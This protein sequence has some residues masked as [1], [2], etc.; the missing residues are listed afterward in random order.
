MMRRLLALVV[1]CACGGS[2]PP[3]PPVEPAP[4]PM[5]ATVRWTAF[6]VPHVIA[7]D[8]VGLGFGQGWATAKQHLCR[9]ADQFVRVR[10]E[11][12]R[13]F[14]AGEG[15]AN[16]DSDFFFRHIEIDE[17]A[18]ALVGGQSDDAKEISR[19]WVAGYNHFL[20][21]NPEAPCAGEPWVG[22]IETIDLA[23]LAVSIGIIASTG[24]FESQIAGAA[25]A[26]GSALAPVDASDIALASNAWALGAERTESG[27]G[28][29]IA[30]P[31]FPWEG[32]LTFSEIHLT[33]RSDFDVYGAGIPGL[34][35]VGIGFTR[36]HAWTHTVSAST[37]FLL[38]RLQLVP[39]EPLQYARDDGKPGRITSHT[40]EIDV[41]QAD[42][43]LGKAQ[44]TLYRSDLGPMIASPLTPWTAETAWALHDAALEAGGSAIDMDLGFARAESFDDFRAA[45][46]H[47]ATPFL[48]TIYA[49][50]DGNAWYVDGSTVPALS[51]QALAAWQLGLKAVPGMADAWRR[52][53]AIVDGSMAM[54]DTITDDPAVPGA[55]P[56]DDAPEL[57]RT[58]F[59]FNAND[60]YGMTNPRAPQSGHSPLYGAADATPSPRSLMNLRML[61]EQGVAAASGADG[62]FSRA[63]A[64]HAML[65]N[66]SFTGE[67]LRD[68]VLARCRAEVTRRKKLGKALEPLC[69]RL[70]EWDVRFDLDSR[71]AVLWRELMHQIAVDG[72]V[73][74]TVGFD[75]A[76]LTTPSG[77]APAE[78]GKPD[79]VI[80][81]LERAADTLGAA[82]FDVRT[83]SPT[84]GELQ[85]A[86][87]GEQPP[88]PGGISLDGVTNIVTWYDWNHTLLPHAAR[89]SPVSTS[90]LGPDGYPVDYGTSWIM[91]VDLLPT[92]PEADVLLT[93]GPGDQLAL[94]GV[95]TLR[96]ALFTDDAIAA[97]PDLVT[98]DVVQDLP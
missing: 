88:V 96:P 90:G 38:Y 34:P 9:L 11:R 8:L 48:N 55:I 28:V 19:G 82:G 2:K 57:L 66:R 61:R 26:T 85:H 62:R 81:A 91:A 94:F 13:W 71:G 64:A 72:R 15:D 86:A 39:G 74:W 37:R 83:A 46:G 3:A 63:E 51:D 18:Q 53:I 70:A 77:L 93:Y 41:L 31:H 79:P 47:R 84:L 25:P 7:D 49:D 98:E 23:R 44:R 33:A 78:K 97:D 56:L 92:G 89:Q 54:F 73:P 35:M 1:L 45:V 5:R 16:L 58:D 32:D 29:L 24:I 43:T 68:P 76:A 22:P 6:G 95:G 27:N 52:G 12:A 42:G 17:Y 21:H 87:I 69:T 75:A 60:P 50:V 36:H 59:V 30:N 67:Q 4:E 40:Y 10:G 14:G 80:A 65:S 20:A